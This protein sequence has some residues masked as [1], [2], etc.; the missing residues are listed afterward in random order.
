MLLPVYAASF[1]FFFFFFSALSS[2]AA[3]ASSS[4][5]S[6]FRF[7]HAGENQGARLAARPSGRLSLATFSPSQVRTPQNRRQARSL[8]LLLLLLLLAL[9]A[10]GRG[11]ALARGVAQRADHLLN[12]AKRPGTSTAVLSAAEGI[13]RFPDTNQPDIAAWTA[14]IAACTAAWAATLWPPRLQPG[15][16]LHHVQVPKPPTAAR[17][18]SIRPAD[19]SA[20]CSMYPTL[21]IAAC[22]T[23][24]RLQPDAQ[25]GTAPSSR[26]GSCAGPRPP[27]RTAAA[28]P[29]AQRAQQAQQGSVRLSTAR[30]E[31]RLQPST[32]FAGAAAA[33]ATPLD[34][35]GKLKCQP[36]RHAQLTCQPLADFR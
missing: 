4:A 24:W 16:H 18:C 35:G 20:D 36:P 30:R 29:P 8:V 25:A 9:L 26:P 34:S 19:C 15:P 14:W 2:A 28:P 27:R 11:L 12:F 10:L 21:V 32:G 23:P 6:A 5:A 13:G 1:F 31:C 17:R 7:L 3:G 33:A 22:T